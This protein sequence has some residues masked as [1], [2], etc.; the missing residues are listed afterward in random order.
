MLEVQPDLSEGEVKVEGVKI[1]ANSSIGI[2][3]AACEVLGLPKS[4]TKYIIFKRISDHLRKQKL[5]SEHRARFKL[6]QESEREASSPSVP[7][8]PSEAEIRTHRLTHL[9]YQPWCAHC[10][11]SKGVQSK[12]SKKEHADAG[13]SVVS[14]DFFFTTRGDG[15][16]LTCLAVRDRDTGLCLCI[17]T[18]AKGGKWLEYLTFEVCRFIQWTGHAVV[19]LRNDAEPSILSLQ[20]S[21]VRMRSR[22][23]LRTLISN[24]L[25]EIQ[26]QMVQLSRQCVL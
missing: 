17:P 10:V 2:L 21:V 9:P 5:L 19:A 12:H 24:V 25:L 1:N 8:Q 26:Q 14:T 18:P 6:Q 22:L 23:G 15:E 11:S 13:V 7:R 20:Q 4:G 3:R 16:Q